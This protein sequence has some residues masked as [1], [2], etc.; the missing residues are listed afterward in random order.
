MAGQDIARWCQAVLPPGFEQARRQLPRIQG[1]LDENLPE[2]VR[3]NVTLLSVDAERI[4][5][6]ASTP[7]VTS[8]LRLHGNEISQQLRETFQLEQQIHFRTIP[9]GLLQQRK[10]GAIS[11]PRKV[12]QE[13][14][15]AI[16]RN[17]QWIEDEALRASLLALAD[18]LAG[19]APGEEPEA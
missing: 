11:Q 16:R 3:D 12:S 17:A 4:V 10:P 8:Y 15:D 14:V 13:S 19:N 18:S 6:A 1:F 2:A 9:D 7:M 5:I